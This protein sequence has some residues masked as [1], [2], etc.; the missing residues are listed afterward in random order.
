MKRLF[1]ALAVVSIGCSPS[2]LALKA[3]T[4]LL[5]KGAAAYYEETDVALARE[6]MPA[7][8]KL[9]E[10]LLKSDSKNPRLLALAAEGYCGYSFLF[11]EDADPERAKALYLRAKDYGSRLLAD[12]LK[13]VKNGNV[14]DVEAAL[15]QAKA[16]D[17]PALFWTAYAWAGWVQL[18][19][20]SPDA[21]AALPKIAA[22]MNRVRQLDPGYFFSG[23]DLFLGS[24]YAILPR[25][26][27]GNP[28]KSK[29]HFEA[30]ISRTQG[31]FLTAKFLYA[32]HYAVAAQDP[33]LFKEL[34]IEV[35]NDRQAHPEA[36]L[37]NEVAKLRSKKLLEKTDDYF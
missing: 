2:T 7:Q 35:Q 16:E 10:A 6:A 11:V 34:L 15:K 21:V 8:L 3:T 19:R 23:A 30:A 5:Q 31:K 28:A 25:M 26:L 22:I 18:S 1:T 36:G 13:V 33:G 32:R 27:G 20:E 14:S 29:E 12:R 24:Y 37:A 9:V 17:V 4:P